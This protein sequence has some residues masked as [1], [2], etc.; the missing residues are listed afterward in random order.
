MYGSPCLNFSPIGNR[1]EA[2]GN[3]NHLTA[4]PL[5]FP[6]GASPMY[7]IKEKAIT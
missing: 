5:K 2:L 7:Q 4:I 3:G 6:E 1:N